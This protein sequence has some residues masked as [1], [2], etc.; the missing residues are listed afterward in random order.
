MTINEIVEKEKTGSTPTTSVQAYSPKLGKT[1]KVYLG[2]PK[3]EVQK[4]NVGLGPG[5]WY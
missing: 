2:N 1:I 4:Y 3:G 5:N